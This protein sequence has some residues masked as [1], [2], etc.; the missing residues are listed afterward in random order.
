MEKKENVARI[1][2][3]DNIRITKRKRRERRKRRNKMSQ[4]IAAS[5]NNGNEL[6]IIS[7][8]MVSSA[9]FSLTFEHETKLDRLTNSVCAL[10]A[11]S[12]HEPEIINDTC[13]DITDRTSVRQIAEILAKNYRKIRQ[14]H[15]EIVILSTYG[16]S[17]FDDFYNK[18]KLMQE[19][20]S[21]YILGQLDSYEGFD[22][23]ILVAGVDNEGSH[24]YRILNP[25][26]HSSYDT[27]GFC[28]VGSGENHADSVFAIYH[29]QKTLNREQVLQIAYMSKK[30]AEMAGG[31][32]ISTDAW[33]IGNV[34]I[35]RIMLGT[36]ELLDDYYQK[37]ILTSTL[38]PDLEIKLQKPDD[39][40]GKKLE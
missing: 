31:V 26:I 13:K 11:G 5:C 12:I 25:G 17:S 29:Y 19:S 2:D 9:D 22:V 36:I 3:C 14:K 37:Q 30:R 27:L 40:I 1:L 18:Q 24:V 4:Y 23:D 38:L 39:D 8:R 10:C 20:T 34:G 35:A 7:D 16:L 28:S 33:L 6:I 21:K 15:L 32:G